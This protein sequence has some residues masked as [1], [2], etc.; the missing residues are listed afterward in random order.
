MWKQKTL[1]F[2]DI[3]RG[4]NMSYVTKNWIQTQFQNFASRIYSVFATKIEVNALKKSVSDGKAAVA[5]AITVKGVTTAADATFAVMAENV[6]KIETCL[7]WKNTANGTYKFVQNGDRWIANNRGINS[8]TATSTWKVTIPPSTTYT[9]ISIGYRTATENADKLSIT[10][11]GAAILN[12]V[13]GIMSSET[14]LA[15]EMSPSEQPQDIEIVAKYV[16]DSSV[17]S[18]GDMAYVILPPIGEQPGQYKY[19]SKSVTPSTSSQTVYPDSG[20]DGLYAVSVNAVAGGGNITNV[21]SIT[22][23]AVN[24]SFYGNGTDKYYLAVYLAN[25]GEYNVAFQTIGNTSFI[26]NQ[27][28]YA[29]SGIS[30]RSI[31][32][33]IPDSSSGFK[34]LKGATAYIAPI[35]FG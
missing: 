13:G 33:K 6:G 26:T 22:S 32:V 25:W 31:I 17:H 9:P 19:Q 10:I 18:Y 29:R 15:L 34:I 8:S 30:F 28:E 7:R 21:G 3:L 35:K 11:N 24:G 27:L 2:L 4:D 5:D 16:K 20:Y 14:T 12:P 23:V 1:T